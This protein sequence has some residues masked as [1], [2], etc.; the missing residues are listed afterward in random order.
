MQTDTGENPVL[1]ILPGSEIN[2]PAI[3]TVKSSEKWKSLILFHPVHLAWSATSLARWQTSGSASNPG[4]L[5]RDGR[6]NRAEAAEP[7]AQSPFFVQ[8]ARTIPFSLR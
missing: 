1:I 4:Q 3:L 2:F 5:A 8:I 6:L 7:I